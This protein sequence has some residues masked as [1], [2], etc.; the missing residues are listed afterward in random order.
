MSP[1]ESPIFRAIMSRNRFKMIAFCLRFDDKATRDERKQIDK[2]AAIREIWSDF[3]NNLMKCYLP[4]PNATID[5]HLMGFRGKCPSRQYMP[6]KSNKYGIRFQMCA[7]TDSCNVFDAIPY[8]GRHPGQERQKEIRANV[9]LQL[10]KSMYVSN[11]NVTI[12]N[13]FTSIPLAKELQTKKPTLIGTLRKNKPEIL[14]EFLSSTSREVGSS[15]FA[16]KDNLTLVSYVPQRNK[17]VLLLSSKH[18]GNE[19]DSK[20]GKP[21]IILEYNKTKGAVDTVSQMCHQY[22]ARRSTKQWPLRV[23]YGM[24]DITT[25][26]A[27]IV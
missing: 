6:R 24:I 21:I 13:F 19:V 15:M 7:N 17:A 12:D 4:G 10:M 16:F 23:F 5:E 18:H 3:R 11:R 22:S 25:I 27:L 8:I 20:N 14:M 2:F 1:R 26:N 9:V